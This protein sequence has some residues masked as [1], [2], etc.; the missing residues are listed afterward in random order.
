MTNTQSKPI[1]YKV[2]ERILSL[3]KSF[4]PPITFKRRSAK[5]AVKKESSDYC[6]FQMYLDWTNDKSGKSIQSFPIFED[7]DPETWCDWRHHIDDLLTFMKIEDE[8]T[9]DKKI[10]IIASVL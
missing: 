5:A 3:V 8:E 9:T 1:A 4:P 10:Q 6:I 2:A 7:V